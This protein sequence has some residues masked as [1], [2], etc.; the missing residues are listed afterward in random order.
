M[1]ARDKAQ[2]GVREINAVRRS[3]ALYTGLTVKGKTLSNK[4][5]LHERRKTVNSFSRHSFEVK[6]PEKK[7]S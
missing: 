5:P 3:P 7:K 1:S 2:L 4:D 6:V